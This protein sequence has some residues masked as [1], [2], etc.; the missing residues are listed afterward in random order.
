MKN[1]IDMAHELADIIRNEFANEKINIECVYLFGSRANGTAKKDSD[2]DFLVI[3]KD[4][5]DR[6]KRRI[7]ASKARW[8][9]A[10]RDIDIDILVRPMEDLKAI[11][12]DAYCVSYTAIHE[13][14]AV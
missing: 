7:A 1:D 3:I 11:N 10:L 13:G 6:Q 9:S 12:M 2:W 5:I 4:N 8:T 14:I